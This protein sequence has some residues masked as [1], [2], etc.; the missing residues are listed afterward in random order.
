MKGGPMVVDLWKE[1]MNGWR[2]ELELRLSDEERAR[3]AAA[4]LQIRVDARFVTMGG[5]YWDH[6]R[7]QTHQ[8]EFSSYLFPDEVRPVFIHEFAHLAVTVLHDR[9]VRGH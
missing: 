6:R 1:R 4:P 2:R 7:L 5:R 9:L 3:V 8:I